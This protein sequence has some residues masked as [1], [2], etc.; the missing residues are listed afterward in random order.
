MLL[1]EEALMAWV[2]EDYPYSV[3]SKEKL[4]EQIFIFY[5]MKSYKNERISLIRKKIA[6]VEDYQHYINRVERSGILTN[7]SENKKTYQMYA[8]GYVDNVYRIKGKAEYTASE[9]ICSVY[10][11]GYLSKINAMAWYGLT[12]KIPKVVRFTACTPQEWKKRSLLDITID[13]SVSFD[14]VHFTPKYPKSTTAFGQE[15]FVSTET[16][17][18]EPISVKNSPLKVS[19]IGKTFID[20]LRSPEECGG[21]DHVLDVYVEN[22]KKYLTPIINELKSSGA[23]KIDIA[24]TGFVLQ[25]LVGIDHPQLSEWQKESKKTRGSSKILVHGVPFSPIFDED[26]SL[27]LNAESAQQYGN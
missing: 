23:R 15:L 27:S 7:L 3:I 11:Y 5:M 14:P 12:D 19:T 2:L 24:R 1:L 22:G 6:A 25:K 21:I 9:D 8:N 18:V 17:Y 13:P 20:M 16:N 10:P 26:W 4:S